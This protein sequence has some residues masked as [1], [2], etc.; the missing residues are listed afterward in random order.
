MYMCVVCYVLHIHIVYTYISRQ[1][2]K[3]NTKQNQIRQQKDN[4]TRQQIIE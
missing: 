4:S 3:T 1:D 2:K